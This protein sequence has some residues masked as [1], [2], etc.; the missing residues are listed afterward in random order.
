NHHLTTPGM[1]TN[2]LLHLAIDGPRLYLTSNGRGFSRYD[3]AAW[4]LWP[5]HYCSAGCDTDTTFLQ[6]AFAFIVQIGSGGRVWVGC[7]SA[8]PYPARFVPGGAVSTFLDFGDSQSFDHKVV[9]DDISQIVR[10][11]RPWL[12][13]RVRDSTGTVSFGSESP[14]KGYVDPSVL[15]AYDAAGAYLG[16]FDDSNTGMKGKFVHGL[17]I[18]KNNRLWIGYDG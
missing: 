13:P 12:L 7:W 15:S 17:A 10:T 5:N 4:R 6:A 11:R 3:G 1:I 14:A 18:T 9:V 2:D 16:S 8:P